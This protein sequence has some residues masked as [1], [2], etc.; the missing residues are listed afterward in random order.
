MTRRPKNVLQSNLGSCFPTVAVLLGPLARYIYFSRSS[1]QA[2]SAVR[3]MLARNSCVAMD[4]CCVLMRLA[5]GTLVS[6]SCAVGVVTCV[7]QTSE[8]NYRTKAHGLFLAAERTARLRVPQQDLEIAR[9]YRDV[10]PVLE[11]EMLTA[12]ALNAAK[13]PNDADERSLTPEELATAYEHQ[14]GW[15]LVAEAAR[16]RCRFLLMSH[17]KEVEGL[18][19][20]DLASEDRKQLQ[21]G[22]QAAGRFQLTT[23]YD[24]VADQLD[25]TEEDIAA[26]ALCDLN[27]Q[28]A[29]PLLVR[30]G[31]T[32][33]FEVLRRLQRGRP[34]DSKLLALLDEKDA[35]V[36]WRAAYALAESGDPGLAPIV[37]RL[38]RDEASEVR[39]Q[40]ANM[41]FLLPSET[42]IR[43]RPVLVRLL[44]DKA[45]DVRSSVAILF[46]TR[47]DAV[48]AK[49]L[50]DLLAREEKLEPWRQSNLVQALQTMTG[51]YFGFIPGTISTESA[52]RVSLDQFARWISE[53]V[54]ES[55]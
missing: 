52:R 27:D 33:H 40:A 28:R 41:A 23:L 9:I 34:A 8:Q 44:A 7:A 26:S 16:M 21:R 36:R 47:K 3:K 19:S 51:S 17:P 53:T 12:M 50:Y 29:I 38:A 24:A 54:R 45:V 35:G 46:T 20:A 10:W 25:G 43:L 1:K 39:V 32:R 55:Q 18:A 22:L 49:A 4:R 48:C 2:C 6:L 37:E 14:G 5:I 31:I 15:P 30:H 13:P 42:F 11:R